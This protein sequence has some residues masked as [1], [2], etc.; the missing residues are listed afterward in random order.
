[1]TR[2][3][4]GPSRALK[5]KSTTVNKAEE[6]R[7]SSSSGR[8]WDVD[9]IT[10][11]TKQIDLRMLAN[12]V[13]D[14]DV[15]AM[16]TDLLSIINAKWPNRDS[17]PPTLEKT[18]KSLEL[19]EE[20]LVTG[21]RPLLMPTTVN[22]PPVVVP[23]PD[24]AEQPVVV[25][26][27][28]AVDPPVVVVQPIVVAQPVVVAQPAPSSPPARQK[29]NVE[30][31]TSADGRVRLRA[32][33]KTM[34]SAAELDELATAV[35]R[36][37]GGHA[38]LQ[39]GVALLVDSITSRKAALVREAADA[40]KNEE[41]ARDEQ[42]RSIR[43]EAIRAE[44]EAAQATIALAKAKRLARPKLDPPSSELLIPRAADRQVESDWAR[45]LNNPADRNRVIT[46]TVGTKNDWPNMPDR[47]KAELTEGVHKA[48]GKLSA[49]R[50]P[51]IQSIM[52]VAALATLSIDSPTPTKLDIRVTDPIH[53]GGTSAVGQATSTTVDVSPYK[54][55]VGHPVQTLNE[56]SETL[57]HEL[58]HWISFGMYSSAG[59]DSGN[60]PYLSKE[61]L[62]K[63]ATSLDAK[64]DATE[65]DQRIQ[66]VKNAIEDLGQTE[67][68]GEMG[69]FAGLQKTDEHAKYKELLPYTIEFLAHLENTGNANRIDDFLVK[70]ST[71][72][73]EVKRAAEKFAEDLERY[74]R[75]LAAKYAVRGK[76]TRWRRADPTIW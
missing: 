53:V 67:L 8:A 39:R 70:G 55:D 52:H 12:K 9:D 75:A 25:A 19:R 38:D 37:A 32:I 76:E 61:R 11:S 43:D 1:M 2:P 51:V 30:D 10:D 73:T 31:V 5:R 54:P 46:A 66:T 35:V 60:P 59:V 23:R 7:A 13:P 71:D 33:V 34:S 4:G 26:Q 62:G 57:I 56:T 47:T 18:I 58:T 27:P 44:R 68:P 29:W 41:S 21:R 16:K 17:W 40:K 22:L 42:A 74:K 65:N 36:R 14:A 48:L 64:K 28:V 6:P 49:S 24:R 50:V 15:T 3:L 20:K 45:I 63:R 72:L 69:V